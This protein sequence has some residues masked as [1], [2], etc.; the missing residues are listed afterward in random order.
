MLADVIQLLRAYRWDIT[1]AAQPPPGKSSSSR[2]QLKR[3]AS[4]LQGRKDEPDKVG[5]HNPTNLSS[6][7]APVDSCRACYKQIIRSP[8]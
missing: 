4:K 1:I 3:T 2:N 8:P 6:A 7:V 5:L